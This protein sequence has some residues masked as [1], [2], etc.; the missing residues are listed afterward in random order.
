MQC[1][2]QGWKRDRSFVTGMDENERQRLV[3]GWQAA[4]R[5]KLDLARGLPRSLQLR[6]LKTLNGLTSYEKICKIWTSERDRFILNPIHQMPGLNTL[7][8]QVSQFNFQSHG[9]I[10]AETNLLCLR[11]EFSEQL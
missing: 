11:H 10:A 9:L 5:C 1:F 7:N 8:Q 6:P 3:L 4:V 2:S